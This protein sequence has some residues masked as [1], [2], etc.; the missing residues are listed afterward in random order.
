VLRQQIKLNVDLIYL[1]IGIAMF[2]KEML[3]IKT[4]STS[5]NK[6]CKQG[7]NVI[8]V[9]TLLQTSSQKLIQVGLAKIFNENFLIMSI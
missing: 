4:L 3:S 9:L 8:Q 7:Y 6:S 2:E 5:S 1:D